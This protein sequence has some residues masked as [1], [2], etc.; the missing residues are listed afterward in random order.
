MESRVIN[1]EV[2]MKKKKFRGV[3]NKYNYFQCIS[4]VLMICVFC[5]LYKGPEGV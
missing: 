1:L 3:L 5:F 2:F 4:L